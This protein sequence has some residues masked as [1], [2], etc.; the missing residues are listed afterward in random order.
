[1]AAL[2]HHQI[3]IQTLPPT[4]TTWCWQ[5]NPT[6]ADPSDLSLQSLLTRIDEDLIHIDPKRWIS[7]KNQHL[8]RPFRDYLEPLEPRQAIREVFLA[9]TGTLTGADPREFSALG[10]LRDFKMFGAT[11]TALDAE[12]CR[13]TGGSQA[14]ANAMADPL[15]AYIHFQQRVAT[16]QRH[17]TGFEVITANHQVFSAK[18]VIVTIPF[19]ALHALEIPFLTDSSIWQ[20]SRRGHANRSAKHW[21]N[22]HAPFESRI[23]AS[24]TTLAFMD[25]TSTSGCIIADE[26]LPEKIAARTLGLP[27]GPLLTARTHSW[28]NDVKAQGAWMTLRPGQARTIDEIWALGVADP[29]FQ[30]ANADVS[31][32]W[33]G[34]IEGAL[35]AGHCAA[36]RLLG[37]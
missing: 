1:M 18:A 21:F 33:S 13:I 32:V 36:H 26:N 28:L 23:S 20:E 34:W 27:G 2:Q 6:T 24:P 8:D 30:I 25:A 22:P 7:A 15:A 37:K 4:D 29:N 9:W 10:I 12:E 5:G 35:Y 14:L 11:R 31:P 17:Q 16:V 19:N 3:E